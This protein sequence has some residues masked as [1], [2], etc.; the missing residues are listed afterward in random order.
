MVE[1]SRLQ[2]VLQLCQNSGNATRNFVS[3]EFVT[4]TGANFSAFMRETR[5]R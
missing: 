1:V 3:V 4:V 5:F 2:I